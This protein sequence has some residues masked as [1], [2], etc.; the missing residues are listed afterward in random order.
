[1]NLIHSSD[2]TQKFYSHFSL[3]S[4]L[5]STFI[6][7]YVIYIKRHH[8]QICLSMLMPIGRIDKM[9]INNEIVHEFE[10]GP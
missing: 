2:F 9:V 8:V 1:M 4:V 10:I 7:K 3:R 6:N 5:D